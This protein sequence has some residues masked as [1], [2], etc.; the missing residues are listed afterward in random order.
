MFVEF[1]ELI[2]ICNFSIK[3]LTKS[4][5]PKI[6]PTYGAPSL[7]DCPGSYQLILNRERERER[8]KHEHERKGSKVKAT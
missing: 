2:K 7:S 3:I 6:F 5:T 4:S 1:V 8:E